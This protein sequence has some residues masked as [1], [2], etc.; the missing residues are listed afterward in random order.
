MAFFNEK[1]FQIK[2]VFCKK[3]IQNEN[4]QINSGQL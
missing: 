3:N 1:S 2:H 4:N